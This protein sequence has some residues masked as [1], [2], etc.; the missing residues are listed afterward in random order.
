M[1]KQ[2]LTLVLLLSCS[3]SYAQIQKGDILLGGSVRF[4]TFTIDVEDSRTNFL[5]FNPQA[6][7]FVSDRTSIGPLVSYSHESRKQENQNFSLIEKTN[8]FSFGAYM[9]NY[10]PITEKLYFFLESSIVYGTGNRSI[11]LQGDNNEGDITLF[12]IRVA[13][14]LSYFIGEKLAFDIRLFSATYS[15]DN[16]DEIGGVGLPER[17]IT[18]FN[19]TGGLNSVGFG[20]SWFLK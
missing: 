11:E 4:S 9:R 17:D 2:L 3:I 12:Q 18:G 20:L 5:D 15:I 14:Q 1:K 8:T 19:L 10:K 13:P 7:F 6:G 16:T